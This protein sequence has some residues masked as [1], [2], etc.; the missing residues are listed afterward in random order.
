ML[1][2]EAQDM[3]GLE[4]LVH[5]AVALPQQDAGAAD[6]FCAEPAVFQIRIPHRHVVE[7]NAH[8]VP[9]PAAEVLVG[10]EQH[11][12][13][14]RE[15]PLENFWRVARGTH[16]AAVLAAKGLQVCG[17]IDIGDGGKQFVRIADDRFQLAPATL[18][19]GETRHVGHGAAGGEVGQDG[20]L[21]RLGEDVCHLRH[22]MHAAED[23][24]LG[25]GLRR[26]ARQLE[27]V[28]GQVCVPIDVGA[29]VVV[30]EQDG[31]LAEPRARG[32]DARLCIVVCQGVETIKL[33]HCGLHG[34]RV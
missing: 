28:A 14:L 11:L 25:V 20:N 1:V 24:V 23:D 18:H 3:A 30:A 12:L 17:G 19:L 26:Q 31:A 8:L 27:R 6:L 4:H 2:P 21:L 15:R 5:R 10:E 29:L 16:D 32:Q 9:A 22:E 33:N 13:A 7:G 34:Y